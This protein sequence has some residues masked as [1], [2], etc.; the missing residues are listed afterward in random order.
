M[1]RVGVFK[2][3]SSSKLFE[4]WSSAHAVI[5]STHTEEQCGHKPQQIEMQTSLQQTGLSPSQ[6][7]RLVQDRH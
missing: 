7:T 2:V 5:C 6:H 1:S 4:S 3:R